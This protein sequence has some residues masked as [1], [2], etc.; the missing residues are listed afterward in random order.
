M[1]SQEARDYY[2]TLW[3]I[4][5]LFL[6]DPWRWEALWADNP[7]VGNPHFIYPVS[8]HSSDKII[9]HRYKLRNA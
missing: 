4:A 6:R 9:P 2:D 8:Y 7:Q 3:D 5:A 1:L